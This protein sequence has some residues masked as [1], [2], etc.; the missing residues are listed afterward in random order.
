VIDFKIQDI[1]SSLLEFFNHKMHKIL[2]IQE[3]YGHCYF[4]LFAHFVV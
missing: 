4:D 2:K 3:K 1:V